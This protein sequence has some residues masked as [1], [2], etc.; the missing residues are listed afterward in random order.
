MV[1]FG[2]EGRFRAK[3]NRKENRDAVASRPRFALL[4]TVHA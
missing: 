3:I 2:M 4:E 1:A